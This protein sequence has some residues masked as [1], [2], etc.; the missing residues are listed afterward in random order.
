ML[1][2]ERREGYGG[3]PP[4]LQPVYGGGI[5]GDGLL[6]GAVWTVLQI[7]VLSLLLCLEKETSE[8]SEVLLADG[9]VN[10]GASSDSLAVIVGC[11]C[12]PV[13]L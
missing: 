9:L 2:G 3:E 7:V 1:V 5:N 8:S 13:S 11:V 4:A 10:G 12:P 6:C